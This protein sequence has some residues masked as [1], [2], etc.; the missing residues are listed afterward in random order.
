MATNTH[1]ERWISRAEMD[2]Y[3]MFIKTW[4]PFNSW[5]MRDF[6][7]ENSSPKRL[8]DRNIIDYLISNDNKYK[9][10]IQNLLRGGDEQSNDFKKLISKLHFELV[11]HTIPNE[12]E[13]VS[14]L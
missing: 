9:S 2:Y 7:D 6:Y 1:I 14:F 4:I 5:Y 3:T 8:S 10:K 13:R 11:D 12:E